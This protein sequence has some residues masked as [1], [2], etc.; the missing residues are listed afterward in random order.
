MDQHGKDAII[1]ITEKVVVP[2]GSPL[3][4]ILLDHQLAF[5]LTNPLFWHAGL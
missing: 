3:S 1:L 5:Q 4:N 2:C